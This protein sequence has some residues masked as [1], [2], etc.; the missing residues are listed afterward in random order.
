[1]F[2]ALLVH[3]HE[4]LH[5]TCYTA[6][7]LRQLAASGAASWQTG[8]TATELPPR[9]HLGLELAGPLCAAI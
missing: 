7:V 5:G 6:R 2:R 1:M 4:A 9:V 3:L 8:I